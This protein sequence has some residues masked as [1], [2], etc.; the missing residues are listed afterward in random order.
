MYTKKRASVKELTEQLKSSLNYVRQLESAL[1][2]NE[3]K[4]TETLESIF[5]NNIAYIIVG[6][7]NEKQEIFGVYLY[8]NDAIENLT[9]AR[10]VFDNAYIESWVIQINKNKIEEPENNIIYYE[11]Q[12]VRY[13]LGNKEFTGEII[14]A[15]YEIESKP[16]DILYKIKPYHI[17]DNEYVAVYG[18]EIVNLI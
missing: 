10:E 3:T 14:G 5:G 13:Q 7:S 16:S 6:V 1:Y 11:G 9:F 2:G 8:E 12:K 18:N 15:T 17:C 4:K